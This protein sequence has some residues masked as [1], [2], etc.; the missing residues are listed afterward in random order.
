MKRTNCDD[1]AELRSAYVDGALRRVDEER[2]AG[3]LAGC[4]SC[5][6]DV[7]ELFRLRQL[8]TARVPTGP[9]APEPLSE[10]LVSIAGPAARRPLASRT[11]EQS[12]WA[13]LP[14]QRHAGLRRTAAV[15]AIVAVITAAVGGIGY[16]SAPAREVPLLGDQGPTA[17]GEFGA[18]L[19]QLPIS[20]AVVSAAA[21]VD[22]S[23]LADPDAEF[24]APEPATGP[25]LSLVA[26]SNWLRR[27]IEA[28]TTVAY[29]GYQRLVTG[30]GDDRFAGS[31]S[32][33]F[34]P[35]R[36]GYVVV[37]GPDGRE[38]TDGFLP[39]PART[40]V[41]DSD[42]FRLLTTRYRLTGAGSAEVVGRSAVMVDAVD[43]TTGR[44]AARWW[45][46]ERTGL[47]LWQQ[48]FAVDGSVL[49]SAGFTSVDVSNPRPPDTDA[50]P[51]ARPGEATALTLSSA[52]MMADRGWSCHDRLA[53]LA[54]VRLRSDGS[55]QPESLHMTY[56]DGLTTV[57]VF[58][59]RGRLSGPP[60]GSTWNE[61]ARAYV[62]TGAATV[63]TWQSGDRVFT[64]V[65][66]GDPAV[67]AAAA[68]QL[69][70]EATPEP[71]TIGRVQ[72]G[73]TRILSDLIG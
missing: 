52:T 49:L 11:F 40:P 14:R 56:S 24:G 44:A 43:F 39:A 27:A 32:V 15:L 1:L 50:P 28:S 54:L 45:I 29:S 61:A 65:T 59:S 36:G 3:H 13:D 23:A 26:A 51:L 73:L 8:L 6:A 60:A 47:V 25:A 68:V 38:L 70:H 7:D 66:D 72:A 35:G 55:D 18:T 31:T 33:T 4:P 12:A 30:S 34:Q 10:R 57:A 41:G 5:R 2:V 64:V 48:R 63:A 58:E 46:D 42:L 17:R 9:D 19:A 69:P 20:S 53:G 16:A 67:L 62:R 37:R 22:Q 71:T 21:L